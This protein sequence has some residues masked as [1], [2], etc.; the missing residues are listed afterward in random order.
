MQRRGHIHRVCEPHERLGF[1]LPLCDSLPSGQAVSTDE[2]QEGPDG[3]KLTMS[4]N[5]VTEGDEAESYQIKACA[6]R[7]DY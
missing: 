6:N 3:E 5:D 2:Y 4:S 1:F 7:Q